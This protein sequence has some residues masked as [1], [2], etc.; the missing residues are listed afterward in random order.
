[1]QVGAIFVQICA[2]QR[3][4]RQQ[5]GPERHPE[6]ER[7]RAR[8]PRA[9][10]SVKRTGTPQRQPAPRAQG[11]G[12]LRRG[13]LAEAHGTA[14]MGC[15]RCPPRR[16]CPKERHCPCMPSIGVLGTGRRIGAL[17]RRDAICLGM[18]NR[19]ESE[20][21]SSDLDELCSYHHR[22][23]G[24]GV[25]PTLS[26]PCPRDC[27]NGM[28]RARRATTYQRSSPAGPPCDAS[29]RRAGPIRNVAAPPTAGGPRGCARG[30]SPQASA[31]PEWRCTGAPPTPLRPRLGA[32]HLVALAGLRRRYA[33]KRGQPK[34]G[35]AKGAP[36]RGELRRGA[37]DRAQ[38]SGPAAGAGQ[39]PGVAHHNCLPRLRPAG[40]ARGQPG[41]RRI[42]PHNMCLATCVLASARRS[43]GWPRPMLTT[44]LPLPSFH[45]PYH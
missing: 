24:T 13:G 11:R 33:P 31:A 5:P 9:T 2:S 32:A 22:A 28:A 44:V 34:R 37:R 7:R 36:R 3:Q 16:R 25:V 12:S 10:H 41:R 45:L 30:P 27:A 8:T 18:P 29:H 14:S 38:G 23:Y 1:M 42:P 35:G 21:A 39:T 19:G 17:D 26:Q 4:P 15:A 6:S 40:G 43:N 20:F